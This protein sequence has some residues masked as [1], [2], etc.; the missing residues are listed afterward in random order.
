L[1]DPLLKLRQE[2]ALA[3]YSAMPELGY[4]A[5]YHSADE[6]LAAAQARHPG[7]VER[8]DRMWKWS[9]RIKLNCELD[10]AENYLTVLFE[11]TS[12]TLPE[13]PLESEVASQ[14]PSQVTETIQ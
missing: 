9:Q 1:S 5:A 8:A 14:V 7:L 11:L 3:T 6:A 10:F 2:I 13:A 12:Q 4:T